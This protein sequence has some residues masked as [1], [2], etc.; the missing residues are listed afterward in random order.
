MKYAIT[1]LVT[2]FILAGCGTFPVMT[3]GTYTKRTVSPSG[4]V[5]TTTFSYQPAC[6]SCYAPM[7]NPPVYFYFYSN[8]FNIEWNLKYFF[9]YYFNSLQC[10][11]SD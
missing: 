6:W 4:E 9:S 10:N 5:T 11:S 3:P 1:F 2:L 7:Y 8:D